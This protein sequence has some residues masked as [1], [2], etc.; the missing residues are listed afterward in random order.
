MKIGAKI[1][2]G[3]GLAVAI[4]TVI[5]LVVKATKKGTGGGTGTDSGASPEILDAAQEAKQMLQT[6]EWATGRW[7][8]NV[9]SQALTEIDMILSNK[10][11]LS[12]LIAEAGRKS[13]TLR[14][15]FMFSGTW[16]AEKT[17]GL[18]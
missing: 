4:I 2:L 10:S 3:V 1:A 14:D 18:K 15:R 5:V 11:K 12:A 17:L 13:Q 16:Y 7:P 6:S 9:R 8:Q